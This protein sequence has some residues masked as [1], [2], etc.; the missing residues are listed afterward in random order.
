MVIDD[1]YVRRVA[2]F[3][4]KADAPLIVDPD[5]VLA[6]AIAL[7]RFEAEAGPFEVDKRR[8]G[9]EKNQLSQRDPLECLKPSNAVPTE[10]P[11]R[12]LT[13]EAPDHAL[14]IVC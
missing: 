7:E 4:D 5:R 3:P 10:E 9:V 13:G 2:V 12:V 14:I 8:T 11:F 1:L 6:P